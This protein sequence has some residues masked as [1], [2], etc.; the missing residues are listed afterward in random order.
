MTTTSPPASS[1]RPD[2]IQIGA[3]AWVRKH[4]FNGWFNSLLTLV[5]GALLIR[6]LVSFAGWATTTAQWQVIPENLPLYF[7]GQ[8]PRDQYWRIW[9]LL[10]MFSAL[11]GLTW[12]SLCQN[13]PR[14]FNRTAL[15]WI[16][17][18]AVIFAL[19]PTPVPYRLL[20]IASLGLVLATAWAG[21][22]LSH[23]LPAFSKGLA[24][25]WGVS[26]FAML[27]L[28]AGGFGLKPVSTNSWGGLLLTLFMSVVSI[29]L[30]F[31]LGV[32]LALGRQSTL[33]IVRWLSTIYIEVIRGIPLIALLFIGSVMLPF[34]LPPNVRL[35][36]V[37]RGI[38]G[39]TLFSSAYLAENV[40]GGLQ[41]IPRGQSEASSAL[42][43]ST[44]LTL[45]LIVLPQALKVAI[46]SIV[47]QFISLVQDTTL[48]SIIGSSELLRIGRTILANPLYIGRYAEVYLFIGVIFWVICYAMSMGSRKLEER[49]KTTN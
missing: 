19:T 40:R 27:W 32:A 6:S 44:P 21:R 23:S 38:F 15:V 47:G 49:L 45:G 1:T 34:F 43:L 11:A 29:V 7:V 35:D 25:A 24:I 17:I 31:P 16:G 13:V 10:W 12:G 8:F 26:F 48:V 30:C 33:P 4:L 36:L 28:T 2:V 37:L 41:S 14:L 22:H 46:P 3:I 5:L 9:I 20:L 42:G 39:L 18:V